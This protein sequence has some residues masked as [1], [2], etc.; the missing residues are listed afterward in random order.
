MRVWYAEAMPNPTLIRGVLIATAIGLIF[1]VPIGCA[2]Y[3]FAR[4]ISCIAVTLCIGGWLLLRSPRAS[5]DYLLLL[6]FG[7]GL[8]LGFGRGY[9]VMHTASEYAPYYNNHSELLA[10]IISKPQEK[11]GFLE[12]IARGVGMNQAIAVRALLATDPQFGQ[13]VVLS[14]TMHAPQEIP[15][16]AG[17]FDYPGYLRAKG[18]T[19]TESM[20][21]AFPIAAAPRNAIQSLA[22][23]LQSYLFNHILARY[24]QNL[25]PLTA[26]VMFGDRSGF[27]LQDSEQFIRTGTIHLI[28]VSGF[29]LTILL[30]M[31]QCVVQPFVPRKYLIMLTLMIS[32]LYTAAFA[33]DPPVVRA[34]VMSSI[35]MIAEMYGG[36]Y[37]ALPTL[38]LLA[39][40]F[41]CI[42][43]AAEAFDSSLLFS[44]IGVLGII[45]IGPMVKTICQRLASK[46]TFTLPGSSLAMRFLAPA[47][48]AY[49]LTL[50]LSF[51]WYGEASLLMP[52]TALCV[53]PLFEPCIILGYLSAVPVFG[54]LAAAANQP[55]L[56]Y[57]SWVIT[58]FA[59]FPYATLPLHIPGAVVYGTYLTVCAM[60]CY[61]ALKKP[62]SSATIPELSIQ[63][64]L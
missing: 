22:Y 2:E 53:M 43:P 17:S 16:D 5:K 32:G 57:I 45:V 21:Q 40:V 63:T 28:S 46:T 3:T 49:L 20:P 61:Q 10:D 24:T 23:A 30:L 44:I 59:R 8:F 9:F 62:L 52:L 6:A 26:A 11:S 42:N 15:S 13:R 48:G 64:I 12:V 41:V 35:F 38:I 54:S 58:E 25:Q 29:K 7:C 1:G 56:Q 27:S 34:A 60:Y 18:I 47:I 36:G 31:I 19:A 55:L 37:Q 14:G 33:F 50:P 4:A 39:G 51:Y